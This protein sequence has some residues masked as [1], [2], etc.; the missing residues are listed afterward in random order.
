MIFCYVC[1]STVQSAS[2]HH[3]GARGPRVERVACNHEALPLQG[4]SLE[5]SSASDSSASRG[6]QYWG[7][8]MN[9][10]VMT[11]VRCVFRLYH[12]VTVGI[13]G[14]DLD[15]HGSRVHACNIRIPCDIII[16][17]YPQPR[18]SMRLI[19]GNEAAV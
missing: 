14:R 6:Y 10:A 12:P 17:L 9:A 7:A 4:R 2:V 1:Y 5:S 13:H 8:T 19:S 3:R 16:I 18:I 15:H 11:R